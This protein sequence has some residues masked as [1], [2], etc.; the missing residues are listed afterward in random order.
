MDRM[1]LS[2][3]K[4]IGN[5]LINDNAVIVGATGSGKTF[6]VMVPTLMAQKNG[7]LIASFSKK[8]LVY[9]LAEQKRQHG[10]KVYILDYSDPMVSEHCYDPIQS[11]KQYE[12]IS[13]LSKAIIDAGG[14]YTGSDAD[15]YWGIAAAQG[16]DG[17]IAYVLMTKKRKT[18]ADVLD[19]FDE[20]GLNLDGNLSRTALDADFEYLK[21]KNGNCFATRAFSAMR[22]LAPKTASC[23]YSTLSSSLHEMFTEGLR[24]MI[25]TKQHISFR[26]AGLEKTAIFMIS[27]PV[28]SAVN[29]FIN[30]V[31]AQAIKE[32]FQLAQEQKDYKLP[33]PV[34]LYFDDFACSARVA[35]FDKQISIFRSTGVSAMLLIQSESQLK[36]LY[37]EKSATT[38]LNNS[39]TYVYM[40]GGMDM[41]TCRHMGNCL[42]LPMTSILSMKIG[43][44]ILMQS[45]Q[46]PII[47]TRYNTPEDANYKQLLQ[48]ERE[49]AYEDKE[50][51]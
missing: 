34:R 24:D 45:G 50:K 6:S 9:S 25:R 43:Q 7:S 10:Y 5:H 22:N 47:T 17:L 49:R 33:I 30:M 15:P 20:M 42:D 32:L 46:K 8:D 14:R 29:S 16:L 38:I 19:M 13:H 28:N 39:G 21:S 36:S 2:S 12:D 40:A 23:V 4:D 48:I 44:E 11:I 3:E 18:F 51:R 1:I 27:S 41:E 37:G 35:D 26:Q 31:F